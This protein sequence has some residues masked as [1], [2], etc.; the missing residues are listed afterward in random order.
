MPRRPYTFDRV[1]RIIFSLCG[2]LITLYLL[3]LLS[4]VLLPFIV[5]CLI[6]YLLEPS[7]EFNKK[8]LGCKRRFFPVIMT[9]LET[10]FLVGILC[11]ILIPYLIEECTE[12]EKITRY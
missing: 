5:A 2:L 3:D 10:V 12:M 8:I 7:V 1:V 4:D 9:L 11:W 6:A